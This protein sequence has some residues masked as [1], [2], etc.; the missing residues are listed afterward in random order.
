MLDSY[1]KA[2]PYNT[3]SQNTSPDPP[4]RMKTDR[5]LNLC[6]EQAAKSPLRNQH[7]C[8]VVRGGK[9][10]GRSYN[11]YRPGFNGGALRLTNYRIVG[12]IATRQ[13][14]PRREYPKKL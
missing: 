10:L 4:I 1:R 7:G 6:L 12:R 13:L 9:A 2:R 3:T 11:D 8:V 14:I 5:Y